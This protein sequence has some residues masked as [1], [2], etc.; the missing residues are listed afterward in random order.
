MDAKDAAPG[1]EHLSANEC[2]EGLRNADIGRLA[3]IIGDHPEIFPLTY[4]VDHGTVVFRSA[5]G[6]KVDGILSGGPL[7]FEA[8]GY[9]RSTNKAW[10]VVI[11]GTAERPQGI[12]DASEVA[13]LP[14]FP[15]QA[16]EKN[17]F[18]RIVPDEISG[19][20]FHV[21]PRARSWRSIN[22]ELQI[23]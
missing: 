12:D 11:K 18:V 13:M 5:A 1:I 4:V 10:S 17:H 22:D 20:R 21:Q 6:S 14:L 15:W 2:W 19:R 23:E 16:G 3:V 7:A 9:D 8:D